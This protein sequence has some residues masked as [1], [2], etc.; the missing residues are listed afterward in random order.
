MRAGQSGLHA[1]EAAVGVAS[2]P[3]RARDAFRRSKALA[4]LIVRDELVAAPHTSLNEPIGAKRTLACS[5]S[6]STS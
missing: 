1:A 5:P 6:S 3:S 4:E 2:H